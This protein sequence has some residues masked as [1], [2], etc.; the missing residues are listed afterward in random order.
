[1]FQL[2]EMA[3]N[4]KWYKKPKTSIMSILAKIS[5]FAYFV[6]T[7]K[8]IGVSKIDDVIWVYW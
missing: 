5:C 1:M 7:L 4:E 8:Q 3:K 2:V 6:S